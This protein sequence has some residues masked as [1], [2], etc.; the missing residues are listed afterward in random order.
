MAVLIATYLILRFTH[1]YTWAYLITLVSCPLSTVVY[2]VL[3]KRIMNAFSA[4]AFLKKTY[5]PLFATA[6][7][8]LALAWLISKIISSPLFSF[9]L[10]ATLCTAFVIAVAY[11]F[12]FDQNVRDQVKEFVKSKIR[13]K[14][15]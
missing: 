15:Q 4:R 14:K 1:S 6:F 11:Y 10:I 2:L 5:L 13:K 3:L 7:S 12:V 9:L 8:S